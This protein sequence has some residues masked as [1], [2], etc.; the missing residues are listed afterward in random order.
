M[1]SSNVVFFW[2]LV[3]IFC[4]FQLSELQCG[5]EFNEF[6]AHKLKMEAVESHKKIPCFAYFA[7]LKI[8]LS[9]SLQA[10]KLS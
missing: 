7:E 1:T 4:N 3:L 6:W 10:T 9:S 5:I 8:L 2:L